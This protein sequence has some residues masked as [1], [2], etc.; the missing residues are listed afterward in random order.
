MKSIIKMILEF[1]VPII[2]KVAPEEL[3][4]EALKEVVQEWAAR[5]FTAE[6]MTGEIKDFA[7]WLKERF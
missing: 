2:V 6:E 4:R 7:K 3:I 1:I 5:H